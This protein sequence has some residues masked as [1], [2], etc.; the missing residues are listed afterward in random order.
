MG[1]A[2]LTLTGLWDDKKDR[3]PYIRFLINCF[4]AF[5]VITAG[6][7][8]PY[9][10]NPFGGILS[11]NNWNVSLNFLGQH[12]IFVWSP[13]FAFIWIVWLTNISG[14]SG[15]VDG[16][17]PGFVSIS[18]FV[19]GLLSLRYAI[20]DPAQIPVVY[21]S[22][23]TAGAFLGFLPWNFYP[24]KIM[25]G[26]GGKTLA[27][28]ML[29][30]LSIL[31]FSKLGT[32]LLVL[33]VP[34]TDAVFMFIRRLLSGRSPVWATSGHL[35]HHLLGLGWEKRKVAIFYWMISAAA[36]IA[37]LVLNSQQKVFIAVLIIVLVVGLILW[38]NL[39]RKLPSLPEVD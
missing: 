31:A 2:V 1:S 17:L 10:T 16:Q 9:I 27:G 33:A 3:S 8:I 26:Y 30:I 23:L 15:G 29:A 38:V 39:I 19:I 21:L 11:L 12:A 37:A 22:F 7:G 18:A 4:A 25:P 14:W 13:I 20:T 34:M 35:H 28:F 24:Q 36:G 6:I 5:L 32:A